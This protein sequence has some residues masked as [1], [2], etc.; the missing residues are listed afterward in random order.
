MPRPHPSWPTV[1]GP[2]Y[3]SIS[4]APQECRRASSATDCARFRS[5]PSGRRAVFR[6][7]RA[8]VHRTRLQA[9]RRITPAKK[10]FGSSFDSFIQVLFQFFFT[11]RTGDT[12]ELH[13]SVPVTATVA[14]CNCA[15]TRAANLSFEACRPIL[16][17][18]RR[19]YSALACPTGDATTSRDRL[20]PRGPS[21]RSRHRK[22][23]YVPA[24]CSSRATPRDGCDRPTHNR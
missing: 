5:R 3:S 12:F 6:H 10:R 9:Q 14:N 15:Y 7:H 1:R 20:L 21:N 24:A 13:T 4:H 17:K 23:V 16:R 22:H 19:R 8:D 18:T 11:I 2:T